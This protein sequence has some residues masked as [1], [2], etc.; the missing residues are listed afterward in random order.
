MAALVL[1]AVCER[2]QIY[3]QVEIRCIEDG[4]GVS[5]VMRA[6]ARCMEHAWAGQGV[7]TRC[8]EDGGNKVHGG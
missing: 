5:Y 8:V 1:R 3:A 4:V 6:W 7:W 2:Q